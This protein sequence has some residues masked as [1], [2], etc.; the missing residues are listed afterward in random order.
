MLESAGGP[1]GIVVRTA[2]G[3]F[4]LDKRRFTAIKNVPAD[5][6]LV[7]D[8][9]ALGDRGA[10]DLRAGKALPWPAG[11]SIV[12]A[13]PAPDG[14][15][16]AVATTRT[17]LALLTVTTK[18]IATDVPVEAT[19][20]APARRAPVG[21]ASDKQGRVAIALRDGRIA[22]LDRGTWSTTRVRDEY[23]Q[24]IPDRLPH[25]HPVIAAAPPS[26]RGALRRCPSRPAGIADA[27]LHAIVTTAMAPHVLVADD[28]A[29]ILRMVATVL[30]KRGYSVET[31]VDGEDA[32]AARLARTPDLLITDVMMPK[33]DGWSLV[34]SSAPTPSSRCCR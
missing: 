20:G 16:L 15:L 2:R 32:Y 27:G 22:L 21:I 25:T 6:R 24:R 34:R 7:S 18:V 33:I 12:A 13:T 23:L 5:A 10:L 17:G 26:S 1:S 3:T 29:W 31:A 19:P 9:W 14:S 4:R 30:E 8:R 28:D 11:H